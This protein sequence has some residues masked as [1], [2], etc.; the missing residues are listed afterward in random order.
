MFQF[1]NFPPHFL[2]S[3]YRVTLKMDL[4]WEHFRAV[5]FYAFKCRLKPDESYDRLQMAF[6]DKHPFKATVYRRYNEFKCGR[7]ALRVKKEAAAL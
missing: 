1:Q 6:L 4:R 5:I 2:N 7:L 3:N